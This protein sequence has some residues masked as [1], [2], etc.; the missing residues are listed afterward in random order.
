MMIAKNCLP[1]RTVETKAFADF[2]AYVR[3]NW[4]TP[5]RR[6]LTF[7]LIPALRQQVFSSLKERI[8]NIKYFSIS[9]DSWTSISNRGYLA[10]TL[11]GISKSFVF[12]S[13]LLDMHPVRKSET[14]EYIAELVEESLEK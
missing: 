8:A 7:D 10:I 11:H 13:L 4:T 12:E 5:N 3:P 1:L 14:G 6:R 2:I 9:L